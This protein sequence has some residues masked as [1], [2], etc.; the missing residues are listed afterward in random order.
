MPDGAVRNRWLVLLVDD[1]PEV[2]E[3]TRMILDGIHYA[4]IP[5]ELHSAYSASEAKAMLRQHPDIAL[6][7]LDVVMESDEAGLAL[8]HTIR[9]ELEN[10]DTQI[11]LRT[12]QPG[13]APEREVILKYDI[14]GYFLKTE[15][16]ARKLYSIVISA[17]RAFQYIKTLKPRESAVRP[18]SISR[19]QH[20]LA[21][22]DQVIKIIETGEAH[23]SAQPQLLLAS[24][25]IVGVQV[26]A[27]LMT[28]EG[29]LSASQLASAMCSPE[30]RLRV[31]EWIL[32]MA[33]GWA[34]A[35]RS[36]DLPVLRVSIPLLTDQ[37]WDSRFLSILENCLADGE[38]PKGNLDL[39]V[40]ETLVLG[41]QAPARDALSFMQNKGVSVTL[42]DFGSGAISLPHLQRLLPD[43]IKI[44]RAFVRNVTDDREKSA[45]ARTI[46]ALAHTLGMTVVAD[47]IA[48]ERDY[49]F[50]KWEGCDIGQGDFLARSVAVAEVSDVILSKEK[51]AH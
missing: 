32:K 5:V 7:L 27:H 45:I 37:V 15:V 34:R 41:E 35:W 28:S 3:I 26:V 33:C 50:F 12:G 49:Q 10:A 8:V 25:T 29:I 21:L 23:L 46:I 39:E 9:E 36:L 38:L 48:T 43:R 4:G 2:H 22:E 47:G 42:V 31:D 40:P 30:S 24:E 19:A 11:V 51:P 6:V 17:L 1:E 44:H 14:N 13:I 16:T 18:A 20:R